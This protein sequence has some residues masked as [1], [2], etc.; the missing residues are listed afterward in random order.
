M[1]PATFFFL[2]VCV[3][4]QGPIGNPGDNGPIGIPVSHL[5]NLVLELLLFVRLQQLYLEKQCYIL[6]R[7]CE[8][9]FCTCQGNDGERGP[10]GLSGLDGLSV[11]SLR[12][13]TF[14]FLV[15]PGL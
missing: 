15:L 5:T 4:L 12:L 2:R 9:S 11:S 7:I 8:F 10:P 14:V 13:N 3:H 1:T 6:V